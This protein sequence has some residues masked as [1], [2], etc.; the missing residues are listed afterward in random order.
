MPKVAERPAASVLATPAQRL[1]G[2]WDVCQQDFPAFAAYLY[3]WDL[4]D[5][6]CDVCSFLA[7]LEATDDGRAILTM[8]TRHAKTDLAIAFA[9]WC[10]GRGHTIGR[11]G[12]PLG[13][14]KRVVY[15][16]ASDDFATR[17]TAALR[18][19]FA[20]GERALLVFPA[21]QLDA[22][23]SAA[24]E[25]RFKGIPP[26]WASC[27]AAG[28]G[29]QLSGVGSD[30]TI[31]D[32]LIKDHEEAN[33]A[34]ARE[35][36]WNWLGSV[37]LQRCLAH[38]R[39]LLIGSRWHSDDPAGRFLAKNTSG[40]W[41][42]M[43]KPAVFDIDTPQARAL[44]PGLRS[45]DWW[46][47]FRETWGAPMFNATAQGNPT[48]DK[49]EVWERDWFEESR[50]A[51][52]T[53]PRPEDCETWLAI[54]SAE[55]LKKDHDFCGFCRMGRDNST[56]HLWVFNTGKVKCTQ[57]DLSIIISEMSEGGNCGVVIEA[58]A[59]CEWLAQMLE[60]LGVIP[61]RINPGI[62]SKGD[63]AR[64]VRHFAQVGR[65]HVCTDGQGE[66]LIR[67]C[68]AFPKD[69]HDDQH[70]AFVWALIKL[71]DVASTLIS[72]WA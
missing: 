49:G 29:S 71:R 14:V 2:V 13:P 70:D 23:G 21:C 59:R 68:C 42:V 28:V 67:T 36:V 46:L 24:G 9:A 7:N 56:G 37:A 6:Q 64:T 54:D 39:F 65:V 27:V 52:G 17:Q 38:G 48:P 41:K 16:S 69:K 50:Y 18:D 43:H 63:R 5:F 45:L 31:G 25:W 19:K 8:P 26:N 1:Q 12:N 22:K 62:A 30:L 35:R 40:A 3:G 47:D 61:A 44:C 66:E 34:N 53:A 58:G 72:F 33:S 60:P 15:A 10:L 32:D 11:D 51:P 55:G 57:Q 20:P 4:Y